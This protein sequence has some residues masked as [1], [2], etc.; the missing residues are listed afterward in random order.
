MREFLIKS[1][2]RADDLV[3]G[4]S[5]DLSALRATSRQLPAAGPFRT[6]SSVPA[7]TGNAGF[8]AEKLVKPITIC[9]RPTGS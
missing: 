8:L 6:R 9:K 1:R 2:S 4:K 5:G 7:D 3:S